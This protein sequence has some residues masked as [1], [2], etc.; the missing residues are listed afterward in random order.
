MKLYPIIQQLK[1]HRPDYKIEPATSLSAI[2]DLKNTPAIFVFP[3]DEMAEKSQMDNLVVQQVTA[4]F[5]LQV[6]TQNLQPDSESLEVVRDH[7]FQ[8]LIGWQSDPDYFPIQ[9][10]KGHCQELTFSQIW[11]VD[12]FYTSYQ[13]R[14]V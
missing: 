8:T 11:W 7:C 1:T 4:Q 13:R 5:G 14:Q 6:V 3:M 12:I 2:Q 9:Y 10:L